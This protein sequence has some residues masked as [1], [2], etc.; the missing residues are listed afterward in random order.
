M[1]KTLLFFG[2]G[3]FLALIFNHLRRY[4]KKNEKIIDW[5]IQNDQNLFN[6]GS[7]KFI[8]LALL[9]N[10]KANTETKIITN[11]RRGDKV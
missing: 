5:D 8:R 11:F 9:D 4:F 7:A 2:G 6:E 1:F 10:D 3:F